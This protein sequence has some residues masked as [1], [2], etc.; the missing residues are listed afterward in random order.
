MQLKKSVQDA[1][2]AQINNE[3]A[4]SYSYLEMAI[5]FEARTLP[6]FAAWFYAQSD[7]E[8]LHAQ[9]FI[10]HVIKRDG[11]V[12]LSSIRAAGHSFQSVAGVIKTAL[13]QEEAVS[14]D[15]LNLH[16]L[17]AKEGDIGTRNLLEWFVTEQEE[18]EDTF[19]TLRDDLEAIGEDGWK[20]LE[21]D[22]RLTRPAPA[23][24]G[25]A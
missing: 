17:A 12:K 24:T 11:E 7:E 16:A 14:A 3:L 5:W 18:E 15:I 23:D 13:A 8:K 19:R 6:G 9:K 2:N 1:L 25:A 22:K 10:D 4:A 21:Y 20:L